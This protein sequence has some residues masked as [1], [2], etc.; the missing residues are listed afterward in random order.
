MAIEHTI[1]YEHSNAGNTVRKAS[2]VSNGLE[3]NYSEPVANSVT[4]LAIACAFLVAKLKSIFMW[5]DV[6]MIIETNSSS[7]ATNTFSLLANIPL[8]WTPDS[9]HANPFTANVTA[10]FA[11]NPGLVDGTLQIRMIVD[12]T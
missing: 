1:T 9:Y 8:V 11:T 10:L 3:M 6:N 12:P 5:T 2:I 7:A 4:D